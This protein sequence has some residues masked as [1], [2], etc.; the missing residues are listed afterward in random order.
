VLGRDVS[1]PVLADA[2]A[3]PPAATL[4]ILE[5]A[6]REALLTELGPGR[7]AFSHA[8]VQYTLQETM[9]PT[10]LWRVSKTAAGRSSSLGA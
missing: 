7:F 5:R 4:E 6:R 9:G 8:V 10:R 3:C 1:L 2:A